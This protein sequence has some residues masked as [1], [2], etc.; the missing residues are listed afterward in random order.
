MRIYCPDAPP[1]AHRRF[2]QSTRIQSLFENFI[3]AREVQEYIENQ[4]GKMI[5]AGG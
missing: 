3:A 1:E 2:P 4:C 5:V